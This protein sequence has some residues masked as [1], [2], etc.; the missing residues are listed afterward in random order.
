MSDLNAVEG[1]IAEREQHG[2]A[3]ETRF[4][5]AATVANATP[6]V[7]EGFQQTLRE[8]IMAEANAQ[9]AQETHRNWKNV[10]LSVVEGP[11]V[12][13]GS[14]VVEG[15]KRNGVIP[16]V[17]EGLKRSGVILS[18]V[19]GSKRSVITAVEGL[20]RVLLFKRWPLSL[21]GGLTAAL[22]L[23]LALVAVLY[24][25]P[26]QPGNGSG[27][28]VEERIS[29]MSP[30]P[31]G[32]VDALAAR[33]NGEPAPRT[34]AVFPPDYAPSLAERIQ[35]DVVPLVFD[36]ASA[37]GAVLPA[38]GLVDVILVH[39]HDLMEDV[40]ATLERQL[41]R[42]YRPGVS[43]ESFGV[44]Q[45]T[46]YVAGPDAVTLA[47]VD[48]RFENGLELMAA[49]VLDDPQPDAPLRI[50]L[51]WRTE[52]PVADPVAV[53]THLFCDGRLVAQRDAVPGNGAFPVPSWQP[54]EGVRDQFALYLP[55]ELPTGACQ[56]Q[57]GIYHATQGQRYSLTEAGVDTTEGNT[58]V[59]IQ[60]L[61]VK[62]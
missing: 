42:L 23:V 36:G 5:F 61:T 43:P 11:S 35:H 45:R 17:V 29:R 53:F 3:E 10:I 2:Q 26:G 52:Q 55:S 30:L 4:G 7:D 32:D 6:P 40:R 56:V 21:R 54:G 31:Q 13:E 1:A 62:D 46:L 8:R 19:E 16:S 57:V 59:I 12:V 50:A 25:V 9:A 14:N 37:L 39:P 38:R 44:L 58:A 24:I 20:G 22:I 18:V 60:Q 27:P 48:A 51:E 47:P 33:L 28:G 15:P 34:V 41:Y 49:S